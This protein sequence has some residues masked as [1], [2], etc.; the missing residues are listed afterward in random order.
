MLSVKLVVPQQ[1]S[2]PELRMAQT[3]PPAATALNVLD[4]ACAVVGR[5][6]LNP[7]QESA[8]APV[9]AQLWDAP[10]L[11]VVKLLPEGSASWPFV[12]LPQQS[13]VPVLRRAQV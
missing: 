10:A 8:P 6:V 11:T 9:N 5:A 2:A 1:A 3:T 12:L 4:C 7:Q 13:I